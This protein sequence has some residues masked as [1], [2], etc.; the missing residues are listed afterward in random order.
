MKE[1]IGLLM[2][3]FALLSAC[4]VPASPKSEI[5][6]LQ[7]SSLVISLVPSVRATS[8]IEDLRLESGG[9][10]FCQVSPREAFL[11]SSVNVSAFH[12]PRNHLISIV[13]YDNNR[14]IQLPNTARTDENGYVNV[15]IVIPMNLSTHDWNDWKRIAVIPEGPPP[16]I[17]ASCGIRTWT[18]SSLATYTAWQATG[19]APTLTVPPEQA[20]VTATQ[21]ALH[22]QMDEYCIY[23]S[24]ARGFRF[25]PN[26]QWVVVYCSL[27]TVEI[28]MWTK[29]KI[30]K[31]LLIH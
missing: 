8:T 19:R 30:G 23:Q 13:I 16:Q 11:G 22:D 15:D 7:T 3:L 20:A 17:E 1:N 18:E 25:S 26:G 24:E 10:P 14:T 27:D 28:V 5:Q 29:P 12:L 9:S 2:L 31:Y 4:G 21:Q 6:P